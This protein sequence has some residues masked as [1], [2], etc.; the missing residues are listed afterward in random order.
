MNEINSN[1]DNKLL[2]ARDSILSFMVVKD[3]ETEE[4]KTVLQ[5]CNDEVAAWEKRSKL[6]NVKKDCPH[7]T[8]SPK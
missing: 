3:F 7:C 2:N 4:I 1:K 5:M 8:E 6:I